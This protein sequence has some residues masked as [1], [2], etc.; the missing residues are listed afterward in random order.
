MSGDV[1]VRICERLEGR[2]LRA[3]RLV[4]LL[5]PKTDPQ[6]I[7]TQIR[8]MLGRLGLE[9]HPEK[10]RVTKARTDSTSWVSTCGCA[11]YASRRRS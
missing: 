7:L 5:H 3:T 9:L 11:G 10:T 4:I 8:A 2:F 6:W 1:H